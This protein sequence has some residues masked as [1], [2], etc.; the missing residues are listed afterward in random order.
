[1][2]IWCLLFGHKFISRSKTIY[3]RGC[4]PENDIY[5][6]YECTRCYKETEWMK[7]K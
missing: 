3:N 7:I 6:Y 1:M 5:V 2:N 4:V